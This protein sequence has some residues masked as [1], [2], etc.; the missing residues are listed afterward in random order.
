MAEQ[1]MA[2]WAES[3]A[4][5]LESMTAHRPKIELRASAL[6]ALDG[7]F[8]WWGQSMS[9]LEQPSFWVGAPRESWAAFGR[10][11]LSAVGMAAP[12]DTDV[13]ST[14]R[15]VMAQT[16][17]MVAAQLASRFAVDITGGDSIPAS[18]PGAGGDLVFQWSL[19]AGLVVMEGAVVWSQ[20]F[21]ARCADLAPEPA[22]ATSASPGGSSLS[23]DK[24][25]QFGGAPAA[26]VPKLNLRVNFI[27]GRATWP[28]RDIFKLNVGSV[29]ELDRAANGPADVVIHG[30]VVARGQVVVLNGNYGLKIL[31]NEQ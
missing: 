22:V 30:R 6:H 29:I 10:L 9:I 18:R 20:A 27:L 19:D 11:T 25:P 5:V 16:S 28:L 21:L 23:G 24:T 3:L 2:C 17:A 8:A 14:C 31:P 7:G 4:T 26:S 15:D 12:S 13:A 1:A